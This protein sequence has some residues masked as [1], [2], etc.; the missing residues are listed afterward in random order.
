M[1]EVIANEIF[2]KCDDEKRSYA[3]DFS[4][5]MS[6]EETISTIVAV[7][8]KKIGNE[9]SD[10]T[11]SGEAISGQTVT[12]WIDGGTPSVTYRIKAKITTNLGQNLTGYGDLK[13][14]NR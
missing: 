8:S 10:L 1:P 11:L 12:L 13:V 2:L 6:A 7:S 3:V 9:V 5:L 14:T 4:A